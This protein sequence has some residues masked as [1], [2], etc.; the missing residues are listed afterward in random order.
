M[1]PKQQREEMSKAYIAAVA[2]RAGCKLANWSQ[3]S[4]CLDV[5]IG[6]SET[7]GGGLAA[8]KLDL[9]LKASSKPRL[10]NDGTIAWSVKRAHHETLRKRAQIPHILVALVLP[11]QVDEWLVQSAQELC[12]RRC[13]YWIH[14][15]NQPEI[16]KDRGSTTIYIPEAQMF[17]PDAL[18][19][20]LERSGRGEGID[21]PM[22]GA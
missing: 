3:D 14:L 9:Q 16:P 21:A 22:E 6:T 11:E 17:T 5:G 15:L 1:T 19:S 7:F 2:A 13:A 4:G 12:L 8:P 20:L 18:R 10:V